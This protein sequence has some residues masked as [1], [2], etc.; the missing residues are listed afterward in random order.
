MI[1]NGAV[2]QLYHN[3]D[4]QVPIGNISVIEGDSDSGLYTILSGFVDPTASK[5]NKK[6]R[7]STNPES[8]VADL[9]MLVSEGYYKLHVYSEE[10]GSQLLEGDDINWFISQIDY[11]Y[12]YTYLSYESDSYDGGQYV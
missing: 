11:F 5:P 7:F 6:L 10:F 1:T 8:F 2:A 9:R 4:I 3:N 12:I